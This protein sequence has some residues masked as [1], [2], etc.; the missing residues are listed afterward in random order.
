M[1]TGITEITLP[2]WAWII[3]TEIMDVEIIV[4]DE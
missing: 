1:S 4:E 3:D 2:E